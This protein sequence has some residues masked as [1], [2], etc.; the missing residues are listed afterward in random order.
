MNSNSENNLKP[1]EVSELGGLFKQAE[2][3][4]TELREENMSLYRKLKLQ[5]F[6]V[7]TKNNFIKNMDAE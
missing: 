6:M 5:N 7:D 3:F 1:N 4:E 2:D